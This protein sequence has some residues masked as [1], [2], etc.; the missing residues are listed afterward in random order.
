M[1]QSP[2]AG[3]PG[4]DWNSTVGGGVAAVAAPRHRVNGRRAGG[5]GGRGGGGGGGGGVGMNPGLGGAGGV[6][7]LGYAVVITT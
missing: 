6:G 5:A 2:T 1:A 7:G 3:S 4:A